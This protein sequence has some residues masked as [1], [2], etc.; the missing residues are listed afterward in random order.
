MVIEECPCLEILIAASTERGM[1][2]YRVLANTL[3]NVGI[4]FSSNAH[5]CCS[6]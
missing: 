6:I 4:Y 1:G 3:K 2:L 5:S